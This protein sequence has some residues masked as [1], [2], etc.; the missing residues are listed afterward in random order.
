[1]DKSHWIARS[2]GAARSLLFACAL[3]SCLAAPAHAQ[4]Q[5]IVLW[6]AM[7]GPLGEQV[8]ALVERFNAENQGKIKVEAIFQGP[9]A[10]VL[11]KL[12]A[13]IQSKQLPDIVQV[14]EIG[15]RLVY[16]LKTTVPFEDLAKKS[17]FS[18]GDLLSGIKDYY[19]IDGKLMALPFNASAPMLYFNKTA[20]KEAGM[21][22]ENPP[23]TLAE[24]RS[25][26]EK[27]TTKSANRTV[28]YGFV[29]AIDGWLIEQAIARANVEYCD[30]GNGRNGLATSVNWNNPDVRAIVEWWG[31]IMRDGYGLNAG[32]QN[33]DAIA[34]F[35]SGRAAMLF[36]SSA[37]M[38]DMIKG[39]KFE[40]GVA[41]YPAPAPGKNGQVLNGGAGLWVISGRGS[42]KEAAAAKFL[43]YLGS[44]QA[45]A[46]WSLGTGYIPVNTKAVDLPQFKEAV[47]KSPDFTK[48]RAELAGV[49]ST[50]ASRGC[51]MGVMPQARQT[52]NDILESVILGKAPADRAL[53]DGKTAMES[54]IKAYNRAIGR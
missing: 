4:E 52:M 27:L 21:D 29:S 8:N 44:P 1:L 31:A 15:S 14:N 24:V 49:A 53:A 30:H 32:R 39:S 51:F 6:H 13:A 17:G 45:Q 5:K 18:T 28:Q 7:G 38:R 41:D 33:N 34:A 20:F 46:Q 50:P 25:A 19:T 43:S 54:S 22:P 35:T 26:A 48:P 11:S 23:R 40:V 9:Y 16:D 47:V 10:D 42:A 3:V 12:R 2:F 37:N 36:F